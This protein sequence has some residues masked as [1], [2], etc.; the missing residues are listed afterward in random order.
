M[1]LLPAASTSAIVNESETKLDWKAQKEAQARERKRQND[2][3]KVE[4]RIGKLEERD[5]EIDEEM[6]KPEVFT[7]SVKCQE[8]SKEKAN[9]L[10]ELESLYEQWEE[11]AE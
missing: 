6:A 7:N 11:L 5:Q 2:L 10:E 1:R 8:L 4:E 9:I 3:K